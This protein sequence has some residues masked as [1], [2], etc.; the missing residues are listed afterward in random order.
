[1]KH[2][3]NLGLQFGEGFVVDSAWYGTDHLEHPTPWRLTFHDAQGFE[4][5][6]TRGWTKT[7]VSCDH[8]LL[9]RAFYLWLDRVAD[10]IVALAKERDDLVD[11][12]HFRGDNW[13]EATYVLIIQHIRENYDG[14]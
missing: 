1:V 10:K 13:V 5:E 8:L 9:E 14:Q 3:E 12:I 2:Y 4:V 7:V 6:V 11:R